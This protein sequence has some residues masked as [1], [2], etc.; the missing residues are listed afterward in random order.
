MRASGM[1]DVIFSGSGKRPARNAA[2]VTLV[3][4]NDQ[5]TAPAAFNDADLLEVTR[6]IERQS[7]SAY[8]ING[9]EVRARDVQLLFADASTGARSPA[10]VR[11]GQIGELIAA[12]PTQRRTILEEAAGISGLHSRRHDAELRLKAAETNL[13]RMEDVLREIEARLEGL[14]KQARQAARYRNLSADIRKAE[15]TVAFLRLGD[16]AAQ[17]EEAEAQMTDSFG[18]VADAQ[19]A[20][21]EAVRRQAIVAAELPALRDRAVETAAALQRLRKPRSGA[22]ANGWP[23]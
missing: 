15:A 10:M 12:K 4:R 20:Q 17:V 1:D 22:P 21:T 13:T 18:A 14:R 9:K 5:R 7:G 16:L 6:R 2:E 11:Q 8:R 3:L 19:S 23:S